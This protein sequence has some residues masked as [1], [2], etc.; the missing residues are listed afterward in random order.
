MTAIKLDGILGHPGRVVIVVVGQ[1]TRTRREG[2]RFGQQGLAHGTVRRNVGGR[3]GASEEEEGGKELHCFVF[4]GVSILQRLRKSG[5][6]SCAAAAAAAAAT[7]AI[8]LMAAVN[9]LQYV[10]WC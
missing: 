3:G 6:V 10:S 8:V 9:L 2:L 1:M 4:G 5:S 7:I